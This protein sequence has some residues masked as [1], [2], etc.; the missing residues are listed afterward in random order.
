MVFS[1]LEYLFSLWRYKHFCIMQISNMVTVT[2]WFSNISRT[3][4][5]VIFKLWTINQGPAC[6]AGGI[7]SACEIKFWRQSCQKQAASEKYLVCSKQGPCPTF[8]GCV[9]GYLFL[10]RE[11]LEPSRLSWQPNHR[12]HFVCCLSCI[13]CAKFK[14]Y[15]ACISRDIELRVL[16][17]TVM[18]LSHG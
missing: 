7:V 3:I 4:C 17:S 9:L 13:S 2:C 16:E 10:D 15:Y 5:G 1:F 6:I 11:E 18:R 12:S 14:E 8:T